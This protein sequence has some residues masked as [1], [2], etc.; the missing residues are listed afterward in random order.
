VVGSNL[1]FEQ[2]PI[3]TEHLARIGNHLAGHTWVAL[4]SK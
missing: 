2:N 4:F 3:S 1:V